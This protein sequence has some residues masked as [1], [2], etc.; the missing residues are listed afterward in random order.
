MRPLRQV[1]PEPI[2]SAT[3]WPA[4]T[5]SRKRSPLLLAKGSTF[6]VRQCGRT[7][8]TD[9]YSAIALPAGT[10]ATGYNF[11]ET[12]SA[13]TGTVFR[14]SNRDG[15]QQPGDQ[16]IAAVT[17]TLQNSAHSVVATTTTA[18]D[19]SYLFAGVAAGN[20]FVVET[21]PTGYGSSASSPDTV[22]D[23]G[24]CWRGGYCALCGHAL[25]VGRL[26]IRRSEWQ[27]YS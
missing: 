2:P 23:S 10:Q 5:S 12:G 13:V 21:Q 4:L 25:D 7:V 16:G 1:H 19:G 26:G 9:I 15:T 24:A 22:C 27:R 11:A 14:D 8:G 18:A 20:Y 17:V 6:W 3:C